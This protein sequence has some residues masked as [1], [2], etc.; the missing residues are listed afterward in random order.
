MD[1]FDLD[2][3]LRWLPPYAADV[4]GER[5]PLVLRALEVFFDKFRRDTY[6]V[7]ALPILDQI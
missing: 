4:D 3:P 1:F 7:L 6:H 2:D 5:G